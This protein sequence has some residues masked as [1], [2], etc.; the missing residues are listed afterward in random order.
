[1]HEEHVLPV[2]DVRVPVLVD[3]EAGGGVQQLDVHQPNC[4]LR[5]LRQLKHKVS[6]KKS[7]FS[8]ALPFKHAILQI[9]YAPSMI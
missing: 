3:G 8:K 4:K 7:L 5:K 2:P 9:R 6:L 1:M